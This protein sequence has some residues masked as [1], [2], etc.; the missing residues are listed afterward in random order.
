MTPDELVAVRERFESFASR[1]FAPL[2]R[3]HQQVNGAMYLQGLLLDGQ[4][5]SMQSM[6]LRLGVDHQRLQQ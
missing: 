1:I 6:A 3:W 2:P 5:K 4:R